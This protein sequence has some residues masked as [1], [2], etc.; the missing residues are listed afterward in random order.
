MFAMSINDLRAD[1]GPGLM[2]TCRRSKTIKATVASDST[3]LLN[4]ESTHHN[5]PLFYYQS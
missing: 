4:R 5:T 1:Q 3:G 2:F